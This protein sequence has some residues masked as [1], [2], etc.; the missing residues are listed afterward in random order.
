[1]TDKAPLKGAAEVQAGAE[2]WEEDREQDPEG[3]GWAVQDRAP[4]RQ[5][6]AY[7]RNAALLPPTKQGYPVTRYSALS[8]AHPW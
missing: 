6:S 2:D 1:V 3:G 8:V 7:V 4:A 5:G